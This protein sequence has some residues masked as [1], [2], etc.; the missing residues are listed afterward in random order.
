MNK[1]PAEISLKIIE[2]AVIFWKE[3]SRMQLRSSPPT[4]LSLEQCIED[5]VEKYN[6]LV[7][8]LIK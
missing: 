7:E 1:P 5:I 3:H 4:Y 8:R 6:A 2:L